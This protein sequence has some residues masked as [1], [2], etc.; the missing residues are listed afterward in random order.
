MTTGTCAA[1]TAC[2]S[3]ACTC[4]SSTNPEQGQCQVPFVQT[5]ETNPDGW[6]GVVHSRARGGVGEAASGAFTRWGGYSNVFPAGGYTTSLDIYLD[7]A[8]TQAAGDDTRFDWSSAVSTS[9]CGFLRDF[10]FNVGFYIGTQTCT[11]GGDRG[12]R[13]LIN[14]STNASRSG[15]NPCA[16]SAIAVTSSGWYTFTHRFTERDGVLVGT[17]TVQ[18][19]GVSQSWTLS[20][21]GDLIGSVGGNR[22]GWFV[23][24]EVPLLQIAN[25]TRA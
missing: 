14:G 25:S 17:L 8:A 22:Y 7:L 5:F 3:G 20:T 16:P 19:A 2:C 11:I 4:G 12:A 10:V 15:A 9:D 1:N 24:Q 21:P 13:F 23:M 18:G 6:R